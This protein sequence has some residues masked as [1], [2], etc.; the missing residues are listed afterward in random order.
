MLQII[1]VILLVAVLVGA[2]VSFI[3]MAI[4]QTL[5]MRRAGQEAHALN[6]R[7]SAEDLFDVPRRFADF[8]LISSGHS[9]RASN[10]VYGRIEGR[11]VRAFDFR[12][13][14]G[15][16]TR[17]FTHHYDVVVV[18]TD[19]SLPS[20]LLWNDAEMDSAPLAASGVDG[21]LARWVYR[22]DAREVWMAKD[23]CAEM[24]GETFSMQACDFALMFF[25]PA[26]KQTL[27]CR[28]RM[29]FAVQAAKALE[30]L[31]SPDE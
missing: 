19:R 29:N 30:T 17:R 26:G 23:L 20:I 18:E 22:G 15:H 4:M 28:T 7:F 13:E 10:V 14:A 8:A 1:F 12:Y 9:P 11:R 27:P 31:G 21:H 25:C 5:R 6:M 2:V 24:L 16:G 3:A